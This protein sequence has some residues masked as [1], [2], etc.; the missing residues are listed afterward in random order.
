MAQAPQLPEKV[1][2]GM[3][4]MP[5][6]GQAYQG[7]QQDNASAMQDLAKAKD[8]SAAGRMAGKE[9]IAG[10]QAGAPQTP[11]LAKF[12]DDFKHKGM[13]DKQMTDALSTMFVFAAIGGA[14][15][16]T[17]MTSAI[18]A[19]GG[20]MEGLVKGDQEVFKREAATFDK[21]LKVAMAKNNEA[22]SKYKLAFEKH[23]GDLGAAMQEIQLEAAAHNDTVTGALA[24]ANNAKGIM[25]QIQAMARTEAGMQKTAQQFETHRMDMEQRERIAERRAAQQDRRLDIMDRRQ[26]DTNSTK[27]WQVLQKPDGS[28]VRI[29]AITGEKADVEDTA[30][31]HKPSSKGGSSGAMSAIQATMYTDVATGYFRMDKLKDMSKQAGEPVG[32]SAFLE[33]QMKADG[34]VS[35]L[36]NYAVNKS[37]P[38]DLQQ[39]DAL[40]LGVAFDV[41]SARSGG[42]G[43]LSDAKIREVT[44]Q[45]PLQ[46]NDKETR[47][48]KYELI[49]NQL[50]EANN[51][52]P[53][54]FR[55]DPATKGPKGQKGAGE[56]P[57]GG[58]APPAALE[59]L[60]ANPDT[61]DAFKAKFGY[62]P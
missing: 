17:P 56:K 26:T 58:S 52:L 62:L 34:L 37:L 61:K 24:R 41:A 43:Q 3:P 45:M 49:E 13:D 33:S 31:L 8:E 21:N 10:I 9:K 38:A 28:V 6:L 16:R 7:A 35:V 32:G 51:T 42:R 59:Y 15:T 29:N 18:K 60:K 27:G 11:E 5:S 12:P 23:K 44:R 55:Y 4:S 50:H 36:R 53:E 39:Q 57:A 46:S 20:A 22:M 54:Q 48:L 47:A 1:L 25:Q 19:F 14:M 2:G 40:L 30:G